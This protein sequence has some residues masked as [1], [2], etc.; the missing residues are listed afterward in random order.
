M[1]R[2]EFVK[3]TIITSLATKWS[4]KDSYAAE[5]EL[6]ILDDLD[7]IFETSSGGPRAAAIGSID[8]NEILEKFGSRNSWYSLKSNQLPAARSENPWNS[9]NYFHLSEDMPAVLLGPSID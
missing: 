4:L 9:H 5:T 6:D 1:K 8:R 3:K 7:E 2:R